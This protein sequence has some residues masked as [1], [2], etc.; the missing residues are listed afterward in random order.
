MASDPD[1]I[2][3]LELE[4]WQRDRARASRFDVVA[5]AAIWVLVALSVWP[6]VLVADAVAHGNARLAVACLMAAAFM[7]PLTVLGSRRSRIDHLRA[8]T[9]VA[10][11]AT[12]LTDALASASRE[13]QERERQ[14]ET[15]RFERRLGNALEMAAD[16][17]DALEVVGRAFV[18][19]IPHSPAELLLA[20]NSHAHLTRKSF[21]APD[22]KAPGCPV[23]S[24][25]GC[26]AAR[27]AQTQ[28]FSNSE[29]LDA[30]PRLRGRPDGPSSAV[31]VPVAVMGRAVGVVHVTG[32]VDTA[33][34]DVQ[35]QS[36]RTLANLAGSRIGLL[37]AMSESQLQASTDTLTGL[38]NRRAFEHQFSVRREDAA[39]MSVAMADLDHF[40]E[41]ND[42]YGHDAGDRALRLFAKSIRDALRAHDL[43]G[44][45]GGEEFSI[46][47]VD[48]SAD[49]AAKVL[50][51]FRAR[52]DAAITVAG[53]PTFTVS[54]G[55]V[56]AHAQEDLLHVLERADAALFEAKRSGRD[57]V[58]THTDS[59]STTDLSAS[60][61]V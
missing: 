38:L 5:T 56:E 43:V 25:A 24:P 61:L 10:S 46:A 50:D 17:H 15:Q 32:P 34:S 12:G 20:D 58:V 37:R 54:V 33:F 26:P 31:C 21:S 47:L 51:A 7:S 35:V 60:R 48:C 6:A 16:E 39:T 9:V 40:K 53:L 41:L 8:D 30:C 45:H 19:A 57:K 4:A 23:D 55:V 52:L 3:Q 13:A 11:M 29:A 59:R 27:R 22:G 42:T 28:Q 44:R 49:S 14:A 2:A 18:A 1:L 36:L